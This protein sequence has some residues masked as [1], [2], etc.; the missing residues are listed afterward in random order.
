[1][2]DS[3]E[4]ICANIGDS[5]MILG[6]IPSSLHEPVSF[7]VLNRDHK[8]DLRGEKERIEKAGGFVDS[9]RV[10]GTLA[11]SRALVSFYNSSQS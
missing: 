4:I 5:R 10:D 11:V 6:T 2:R 9:G 7:Q 8:P 3:F 1:M